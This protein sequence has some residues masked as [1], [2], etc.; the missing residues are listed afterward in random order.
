[1]FGDGDVVE[2]AVEFAVAAAAEPVPVLGLSGGGRDW[3]GSA[4]SGEGR[5]AAASAGV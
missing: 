5:F 4:E 2:R 1:L 3:C